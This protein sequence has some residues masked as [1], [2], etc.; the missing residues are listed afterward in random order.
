M[1]T[2]IDKEDKEMI[3]KGVTAKEAKAPEDDFSNALLQAIKKSN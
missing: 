2:K 1:S 3:E